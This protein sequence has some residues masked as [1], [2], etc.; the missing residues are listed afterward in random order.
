MAD[1][2]SFT[3]A[4]LLAAGGVM[5]YV[6]AKS[7]PSLLGGLGLALA[8]GYS[9]YTIREEFNLKNG[10]SIGATASSVLTGI[11]VSRLQKTKKF[12]PAGLM[13]VL[14]ILATGYYGYKF[15]GLKSNL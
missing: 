8:Y 7:V 15:Y 9:G 4:G 13:S 6:K 10:Y 14:G 2:L 12:M 5:G 3:L 11:G 1:H